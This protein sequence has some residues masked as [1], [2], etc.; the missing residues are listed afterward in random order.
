MMH[1]HI[2]TTNGDRYLFSAEDGRAFCLPI[3]P[4]VG[5]MRAPVKCTDGDK[6]CS[7]QSTPTPT[8]E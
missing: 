5:E 3:A 6:A 1:F 2:A 4:P 8:P 7:E